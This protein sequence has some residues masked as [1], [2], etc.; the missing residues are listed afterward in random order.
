MKRGLA[1]GALVVMA[2]IALG[3]FL[4][5]QRKE[6]IQAAN[7][8]ALHDLIYGQARV[9]S[10]RDAASHSEAPVLSNPC[11]GPRPYRNWSNAQLNIALVEHMGTD[12]SVPLITEGGCRESEGRG[13][14]S[15]P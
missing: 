2:A 11:D 7:T 4:G 15:V 10:V 14:D 6:R 5:S 8:Q 13:D 3:W 9:G 12:A 1:I